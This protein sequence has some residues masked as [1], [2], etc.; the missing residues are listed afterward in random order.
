MLQDK[1]KNSQD[2]E[3]L[4]K[5]I[6]IMTLALQASLGPVKNKVWVKIIEHLM[7][8]LMFVYSSTQLNGEVVD[9][10]ATRMFNSIGNFLEKMVKHLHVS[11]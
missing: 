3:L 1:S 2:T 7:Q 8:S 4:H 10:E 9:K 11:I 6:G 5:Q